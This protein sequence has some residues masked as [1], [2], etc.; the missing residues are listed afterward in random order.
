MREHRIDE[1]E[2]GLR[3]N[4]SQEAIL[5]ESSKKYSASINKQLIHQKKRKEKKI[6]GI[7]KLM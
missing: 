7:I 5:V 2:E 3:M 4:T 1:M 6:T